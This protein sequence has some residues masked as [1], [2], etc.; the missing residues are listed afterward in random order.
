M[1]AGNGG[2]V[3]VLVGL[4]GSAFLGGV[5]WSWASLSS[6]LDK[7]DAKLDDAKG[8]VE[9]LDARVEA[10][11]RDWSGIPLPIK[12]TIA[13]TTAKRAQGQRNRRP[14]A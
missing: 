10:L 6:K 4:F 8:S 11:E 13:Q 7:L 14:R 12:K 3:D 1:P 9:N 5:G 2:L